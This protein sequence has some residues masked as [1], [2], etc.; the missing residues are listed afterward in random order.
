METPRRA[1]PAYSLSKPQPR[2]TIVHLRLYRG[3]LLL[4]TKMKMKANCK[5]KM[6]N[7]PICRVQQG[8]ATEACQE[9]LNDLTLVNPLFALRA[10][11]YSTL[12]PCKKVFNQLSDGFCLAYLEYS[13]RSIN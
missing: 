9:T 1:L 5:Y 10:L 3:H 12:S 13:F 8:T 2:M 7:L 4:K 6:L 11:N